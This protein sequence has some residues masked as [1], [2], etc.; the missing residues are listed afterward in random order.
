[1]EGMIDVS[2]LI[3][4]GFHVY[5]LM[6]DGTCIYVGKTTNLAQRLCEQRRKHDFDQVFAT[7]CNNEQDMNALEYRLIKQHKPANNVGDREYETTNP[8]NRINPFRPRVA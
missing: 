5:A 7:E 1:M 3:T 6:K 8:R 2:H 4:K